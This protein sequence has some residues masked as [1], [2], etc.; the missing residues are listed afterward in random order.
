MAGV[1]EAVAAPERLELVAGE[2]PGAKDGVARVVGDHDP[3]ARI[4]ARAGSTPCRTA[5]R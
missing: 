4:P 5:G 2:A 3:A 1:G